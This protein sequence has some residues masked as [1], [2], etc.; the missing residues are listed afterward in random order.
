MAGISKIGGGGA[1][2]VDDFLREE[3]KKALLQDMDQ[4]EKSLTDGSLYVMEQA[5]E[6]CGS[7]I[8]NRDKVI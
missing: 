8:A 5:G 6:I 2:E 1:V 3:R 7:I 4:V